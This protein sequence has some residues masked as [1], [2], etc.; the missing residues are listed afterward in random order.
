MSGEFMLCQYY[1]T[2]GME[3]SYKFN[4]RKCELNQYSMLNN[5]GVDTGIT[6]KVDLRLEGLEL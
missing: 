5:K 1:W 4:I 2:G 6:F 3:I